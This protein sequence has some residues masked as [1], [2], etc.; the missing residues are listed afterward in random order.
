MYIL[1]KT[2]WLWKKRELRISA[3][4]RINEIK[5]LT[6]EAENNKDKLLDYLLDGENNFFKLL[7]DLGYEKHDAL[8][9]IIVLESK[10]IK[11]EISPERIDRI[12]N[13]VL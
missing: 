9:N 3:K 5:S 1:W 12:K 4:E 6:E 8:H 2:T 7:N 13:S 11:L 10:L